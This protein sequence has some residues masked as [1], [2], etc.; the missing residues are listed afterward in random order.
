[1]PGLEEEKTM[2]SDNHSCLLYT[3]NYHLIVNQLCAVLS[4]S[5]MSYSLQPHGL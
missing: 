2:G 4:R 3:R 5:V 1:M